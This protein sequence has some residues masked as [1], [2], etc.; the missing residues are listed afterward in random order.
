MSD[1][2]LLGERFNAPSYKGWK[3]L[4]KATDGK[5]LTRA[6][7]EFFRE[8]FSGGRPPPKKR[9]QVVLWLLGRRSGKSE[10]A[11]ARITRDAVTATLKG[12]ETGLCGLIS[13]SRSHCRVI[14]NYLRDMFRVPLLEAEVEDF[15]TEEV[16]LRNNSIIGVQ[17]CRHEAGRGYTGISYICEESS[18][19]RNEGISRDI[20]I[21]RAI[22][23]SLATTGGQVISISTPYM[24]GG[25]N[26]EVH[27]KYFGVDDPDHLVIRAASTALNPTL[28]EDWIRKQIELDPE[29]G[30]AEWLAEFRKDVSNFI[31]LED[32][33]NAV[34]RGVCS[35]P[36]VTEFMGRYTAFA[37]LAGGK[38]DSSCLA[39]SHRDAEDRLWLD[40][41]YEEVGKHNPVQFIEKAA[42]IMAEYGCSTIY[43]DRY[44]SGLAET[45]WAEN[46]I[47]FR[48]SEFDKSGI[49]RE[50]LPLI[51]AGKVRLLDNNR[52]VHQ[53][54]TLERKT[55]SGGK[56]RIDHGVGGKDDVANA[57]AGAIVHSRKPRGL[58]E[59]VW[60]SL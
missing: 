10:N 23:P 24:A 46:G 25:W 15:L 47:L 5:P 56:D 50:F 29:S 49:Y 21:I 1:L 59:L 40:F 34:E 54:S 9:P 55:S 31:G 35:R 3:T 51:L 36:P 20:E 6:E 22:M 43:A 33:E 2:N 42:G 58:Q 14:L 53:F 30:K 39:I 52:M 12:G 48:A 60:L 32:L 17:T 11:S 28:N 41:L 16:R 13:W 57:C 26:Y 27:E 18:F 37:D 45:T 7:E 44:A 8:E 19:W 38:G 4:Q